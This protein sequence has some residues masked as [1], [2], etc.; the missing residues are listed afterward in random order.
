M[1][2]YESRYRD[3]SIIK[4]KNKASKEI[5]LKTWCFNIK[6]DKYLFCTSINK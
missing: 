6:V 2:R 1:Q 3:D 4:N 5:V